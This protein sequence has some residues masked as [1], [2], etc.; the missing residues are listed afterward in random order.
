MV[1]RRAHALGRD[2]ARS[3]RQPRHGAVGRHQHQA[4]L[5][6]DL[7]ARQRPRRPRRRARRR[8]P[9]GAVGLP[10]RAPGL[11]PDRG[12]GRRPRHPARAVR[13]RAPHR[14]GRYRLQ[15]LD[16]GIRRLPGVRGDD[17]DPA[18]AAAG[19][20]RGE[21]VSGYTVD[22]RI[23]WTEWVPFVVALAAFFLLPEYLSLDERILIII[24]FALSLDLILGYGG[25]VTLG[26]SAFFG[27]GAYTAGSLRAKLGIQD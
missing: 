25:I 23:R 4:A 12:R 15:V 9:P 6:A 27:L 3:G 20:V 24:L 8:H 7:R 19:I 13:G 16:P 21:D 2:G 17:R 5:H 26:H 11:L 1:R 10:V 18:V 14:R 22:A